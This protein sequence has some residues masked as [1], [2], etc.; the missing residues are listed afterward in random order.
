MSARTDPEALTERAALR[1]RDWAAFTCALLAAGA[2]PRR[3]AAANDCAPRQNWALI[4]GSE[5]CAMPQR[6]RRKPGAVGV[7]LPSRQVGPQFQEVSPT[8]SLVHTRR[9]KEASKRHSEPS[10][11]AGLASQ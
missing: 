10:R 2:G 11:R 3:D 9:P 6:A 5:D 1:P 7:T 8:R 4:A